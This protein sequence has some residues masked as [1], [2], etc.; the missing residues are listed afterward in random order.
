[1]GAE[2]AEDDVGGAEGR[3][4]G[5][6]EAEATTEEGEDAGLRQM[7]EATGDSDGGHM[8]NAKVRDALGDE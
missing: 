2:G 8:R 3:H 6:D 7:G 1:M 4:R 5:G